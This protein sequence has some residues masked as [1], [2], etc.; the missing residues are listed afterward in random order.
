MEAQQSYLIKALT[1][2]TRHVR[3]PVGEKEL[4]EILQTVRRCGF[5]FEE[6]GDQ[7]N[8]T[9]PIS[10][11]LQGRGP[12]DAEGGRGHHSRKRKREEEALDDSRTPTQVADSNESTH[13]ITLDT[14]MCLQQDDLSIHQPCSE[15]VDDYWNLDAYW[16]QV[17]APF[18]CVPATDS[19]ETF[20][21]QQKYPLPSQD[22]A[23]CLNRML[24]GIFQSS[25]NPDLYTQS[26]DARSATGVKTPIDSDTAFSSLSTFSQPEWDS[27]LWWDPSLLFNTTSDTSPS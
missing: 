8:I 1:A 4:K 15:P 17:A 3:Q 23:D 11:I 19:S 6:A 16:D 24:D 9:K 5:D 2:V 26:M 12:E 27:T 22:Q 20:P 21:A 10:E 18:Q 7:F 14:A 25:Y 13:A